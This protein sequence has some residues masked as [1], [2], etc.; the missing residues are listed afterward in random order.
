MIFFNAC[1]LRDTKRLYVGDSRE[2]IADAIGI[3][4][5]HRQKFIDSL[6]LVK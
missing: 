6:R 1:D 5:E 4:E 3:D 2:E